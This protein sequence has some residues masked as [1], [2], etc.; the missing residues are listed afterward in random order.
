[1]EKEK[2]LDIVLN[3]Q[4]F[5]IKDLRFNAQL[6]YML[7]KDELNGFLET[8]DSFV[9]ENN[10][11]FSK[12]PLKSFNSK[13]VFFVVGNYLEN[14][15]DEYVT[16]LNE[17][18]K[19]NEKFFLERH[20]DDIMTSRLFSEIEGT[21]NIEN[22]PTT[23]KKVQN[24]I[25]TDN[26][27]DKN[28][29][30][31]K[32]M[33]N[34][35]KYIV[36]ERPQ[37]NRENLFKLYSTLSNNCLDEEDRLNDG[38]YR[39]DSVSIGPYDG[40][41]HEK[42]E[43]LMDSMFAFANDSENVKKYKHFLPHICHYYVL[44]VHPYF[45]YNGRTARMVSFWLACLN[46]LVAAP[47]FISEAINEDKRA[48]YDAVSNTRDTNNDLTYFLGY[49]FETST[50]F[51]LI[52]K[53]VEEIENRLNK[54][55]DFLSPSEKTYIKKILVHN[56]DGYFNSKKFMEYINGTM[57]KQGA[58]KILNGLTRYG[59]LETST[60]KKG[61]KIYRVNQ[62]MITYKYN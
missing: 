38:Y 7:S 36:K 55:G 52:Y 25:N 21:L 59:V 44:Y 39:D 10:K 9:E 49:I 50:K 35:I 48:Y 18:L 5:S 27:S 14:A 4:Y 26:L 11:Y 23:H 54:S 45:D 16:T 20:I 12:L 31:V 53:N 3:E 40:A 51:S 8:K 19:Q 60:N 13:H 24:V 61:E 17:D 42:I 57:T 56:A 43:E 6:G 22:V 32:N 1:M 47:F 29:I 28:D 46:S 58:L 34:A 2:V 37:F 15:I 33:F 30:I 41:P 62:E